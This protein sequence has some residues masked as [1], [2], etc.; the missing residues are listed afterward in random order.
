MLGMVIGFLQYAI[1]TLSSLH[2]TRH[3]SNIRLQNC[4]DLEIW[5]RGHSGSLKVVPFDRLHMVS[6]YCP[7]VSLSVRC[8]VFEIFDSKNA[9]TLKSELRVREGH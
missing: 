3:F 5:V 4:R 8:T 9:M 6:Y 7:I 1:V 2:K